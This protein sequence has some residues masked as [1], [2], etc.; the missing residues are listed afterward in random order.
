MSGDIIVDVAIIEIGERAWKEPACVSGT[1]SGC[2]S[3]MGTVTLGCSHR[4]ILTHQSRYNRAPATLRHEFN[5]VARAHSIGRNNCAVGTRRNLSVTSSHQP[6]SA[7][8][9]A[10]D[11]VVDIVALLC[12]DDFDRG[13]RPK[14][15]RVHGRVTPSQ[16]CVIVVLG[17]WTTHQS[18]ASSGLTVG[19]HPVK[20]TAGSQSSAWN[21]EFYFKVHII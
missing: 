14:N 3:L 9:A 7:T 6:A 4:H 10:V 20:P 17:P 18:S 15:K 1:W 13:N 8:R 11:R 21:F 16:A 19:W 5:G 12:D 2:T